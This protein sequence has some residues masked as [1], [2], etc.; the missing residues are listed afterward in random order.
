MSLKTTTAL[1]LHM[2][3]HFLLKAEARTLSLPKV[4]AMTDLDAFS[5]F[6]RMRW[7]EAEEVTCPHCDT[8]HKHYVRSAR[9]I[10]RC[11]ACGDD[12]S[13]TSGTVFAHHKLPLRLYLAAAMLYTNAVKAALCSNHTQPLTAHPGTMPSVVTNRGAASWRNHW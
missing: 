5:V 12:F 10:W 13:V 9:L 2:P 1:G 11:A 3:L 8:I 6:R 4:L 7:G